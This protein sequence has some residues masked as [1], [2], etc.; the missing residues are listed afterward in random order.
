[1]EDMSS[2][3]D[4]RIETKNNPVDGVPQLEK[5][6]IT[7]G[8]LSTAVKVLN[9]VADLVPNKKKRKK[10]KGPDTGME[11]YKHSNLRPLRKAI[12]RCLEL[13]QKQMYDG[14][15]KNQFMEEKMQ[16]RT[17]KRQKMAERDLQKKYIADTTLRRGRIERLREKQSEAQDEETAKLQQMMMIPDGHVE[18]NTEPKMLANRE[19][20]EKEPIQ[21]PKLRSCYVCKGRFREL[22]HFYDQLCPSCASF[23]WEKRHQT[24]D[25][26]NKVAIVTGS[27]VKIGYQTS[28]KLLRAGATVVATTRFP[29]AAAMTYRQEKD[30]DEWKNRLHVYGLDLRDVTGIEAFCRFLKMAYSECG[31]DILIN[32][33]CQT[34][35]RPTAYYL[36]ICQK[37]EKIWR[38]ADETHKG[39]L[40]GCVEFER[41]RR[42]LLSDHK[43]ANGSK[44]DRLGAGA[45][46]G[47]LGLLGNGQSSPS[48]PKK[49]LDADCE[50]SLVVTTVENKNTSPANVAAPFESTGISHSAAMSQMILLPEDAGIDGD[51]LPP[52]CTDING[53]QLDLRKTN[54]WLLKME[55]VSTPEVM[56]CMFINAIAPFVLNSRLKPL[57]RIPYS[58]QDRYII[59]VSAMEGK[60]ES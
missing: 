24:C 37:E 3:S 23:N 45:N 20:E 50:S 49:E 7:F 56:E 54:S 59:N 6:E 58:H 19:D 32:N 17:L 13:H 38:Q 28:L 31:I 40:G 1:M 44:S 14:K 47:N 43:Q 36:P 21:L 25:L 10:E 39:L 12:A 35:R 29:N 52:G 55:E 22:H 18:T 27:R 42:R 30:F 9:A 51:I 34:V 5:A 8:E 53:Q 2:K 60:W 11:I 4:E 57:M 16:D 26:K 48:R 46:G 15:T 33:A 41:V